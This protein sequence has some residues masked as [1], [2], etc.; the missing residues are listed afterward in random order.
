MQNENKINDNLTYA[1]LKSSIRLSG[2]LVSKQKS[3]LELLIN[4]LIANFIL[5]YLSQMLGFSC[6]CDLSITSSSINPIS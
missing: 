4:I 1:H 3:F 2:S 6:I 5:V